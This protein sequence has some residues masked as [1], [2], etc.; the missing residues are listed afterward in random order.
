[1]LLA[2]LFRANSRFICQ[3]LHAK[4]YVL[5]LPLAVCVFRENAE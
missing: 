1:M 3:V 4:H 5:K 2:V